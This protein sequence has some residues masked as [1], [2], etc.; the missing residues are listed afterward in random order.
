MESNEDEKFFHIDRKG[1]PLY[2]NRYDE[3]TDFRDSTATAKD[4]RITIFLSIKEDKTVQRL[5][6]L[7]PKK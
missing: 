2:S 6:I 1:V 5:I 4:G 7:T 3:I